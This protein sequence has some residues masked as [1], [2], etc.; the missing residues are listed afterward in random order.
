MLEDVS[1]S[2]T[3][4]TRAGILGKNGAG[5][6]TLIQLMM[7]SLIP[8]KGTVSVLRQAKVV[9]FNQHHVDSL[10]LSQC[11]LT[12]LHNLFPEQKEQQLRN[13]LGSFGLQGDLATQSMGLC[14]GGQR[15]RIA[16]CAIALQ[17][18][19]V[20]ILDEPTNHLDSESIEALQN[21]CSSFPG[22]I[23]LVSHN[24]SFMQACVTELHLLEDGHLSR[25]DG[26]V[27]DYAETIK[28]S[29]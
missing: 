22:A 27:A 29:L 13:Q 10:D 26:S 11:A 1:F 18:P 24:R 4:E 23:V 5:K 17:C 2:V 25:F 6:S 9:W 21:A 7:E 8:S 12:H 19:H 14:S 20:M 28:Q 15:T 3:L 16:L